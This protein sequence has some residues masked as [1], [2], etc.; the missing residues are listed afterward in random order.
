[1]NSLNQTQI[2]VFTL[3]LHVSFPGDHITRSFVYRKR[4]TFQQATDLLK[5]TKSVT[6]TKFL[7]TVF[8]IKIVQ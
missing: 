8:I 7:Q 1:M 3:I 5:D 6:A 4:W 2:Q